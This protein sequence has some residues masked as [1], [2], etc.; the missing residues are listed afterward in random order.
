MTTEE[1]QAEL[2]VFYKADGKKIVDV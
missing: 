1:L 2:D